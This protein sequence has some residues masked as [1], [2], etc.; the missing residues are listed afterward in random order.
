M[1]QPQT[2]GEIAAGLLLGPS[3]LGK[4]APDVDNFIFTTQTAVVFSSTQPVGIDAA[5]VPGR[6]GDQLE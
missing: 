5:H 1:G 2:V 4:F 6:A 3:L